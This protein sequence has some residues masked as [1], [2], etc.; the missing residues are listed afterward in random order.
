MLSAAVASGCAKARAESVPDGPPLQVPEP[1]PRAIVPIEEAVI[2]APAPTPEAPQPAPAA[3]RTPPPRPAAESRPQPT[4]AAEPP[5]ELRAAPSSANAANERSV[6]DVLTRALRD[7]SRVNYS[8]LSVDGRATY[9]QSK[10]F[11]QQA[12]E[13]LRERNV[14]FAATLA[15]KAA[16]LAAELLKQ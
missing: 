3:P 13:A 11:S 12:E 16:T 6:R 9:D 8:R 5:R 2:A 15:D 14:V 7:L 1:P 10:R 4:P